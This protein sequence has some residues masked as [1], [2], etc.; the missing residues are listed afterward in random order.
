MLI[1]LS[2]CRLRWY[3][4]CHFMGAREET[5]HFNLDFCALCQSCYQ[6]S[7]TDLFTLQARFAYVKMLGLFFFP[8]FFSSSSSSTKREGRLQ[9]VF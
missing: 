4:F 2:G 7:M 9:G 5:D 8:P 1:Q 3:N 6:E